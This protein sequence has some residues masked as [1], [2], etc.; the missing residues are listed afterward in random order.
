MPTTSSG[1]V[2]YGSDYNAI[3][4]LVTEVLG[5]GSP[6]GPG[7]GNPTYGYNQ[8]PQSS[9]VSSGAVITATQWQALVNDVNTCYLHQNNTNFPGYATAVSGGVINASLYNSMFTAI[10]GCVTNR[11]QAAAAQLNTSQIG[12]SVYATSW[13]GGVSGINNV[14]SITFASANDL[15]YFFNQG[16]AIRFGGVGPNTS[17]YTQDADWQAALAGF[18]YTINAAEFPNLTGTPTQRFFSQAQPSPYNSNYISLNASV[19]GATINW[20]ITYE[21]AHVASGSPTPGPDFVSAGAGYN[22]YLTKAINSFTG[23]VNT[24]LSITNTWTTV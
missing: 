18:N 8:V 6:Y 23:T 14:G 20:S 15:Q 11:L 2:I 3:Q 22:L 12:S 5:T 17:G 7:T 10:T 1:S 4:V 21:D 24:A 9:L 16:G 13:G 19:T